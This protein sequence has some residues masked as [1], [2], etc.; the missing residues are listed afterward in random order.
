MVAVNETSPEIKLAG[1]HRRRG[2][3]VSST[4]FVVQKTMDSVM[5]PYPSLSEPRRSRRLPSPLRVV[6]QFAGT[7]TAGVVTLD[8]DFGYSPLGNNAAFVAAIPKTTVFGT[9][10]TPANPALYD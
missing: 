3:V 7:S 1:R 2:T 9:S 4:S 6:R 8:Q 5:P 10:G